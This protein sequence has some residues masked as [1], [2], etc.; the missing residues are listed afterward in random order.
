MT[1]SR[2]VLELAI[3][4]RLN[5][6]GRGNWLR[7]RLRAAVQGGRLRLCQPLPST[8][9]LARTLGLARGTVISAIEHLKAEGYLK[10]TPGSRI[11]VADTLPEAFLNPP[12]IP[13]RAYRSD[14]NTIALSKFATRLSPVNYYA[15]PRTVAFR[16]NFPAL[17]LFPID[18]WTKVTTRQWRRASTSMLAGGEPFGYLPLRISL[19]NYLRTARSVVCDPEQILITSGIQESLDL[20]TRILVNS[21]DR[22]L[23]EDPGFQVATAGFEAAGARVIPLSIDQE[24]AV[25]PAK[26]G[27]RAR[28][29]YVTPGH[30]FP[31]GATM[32]YERRV[33]I[34][35]YARKEETCIFE[36]DYDSEFRF[37][38]GPLPALQSL[39]S[40]AHVVFAGSFN[41]TLFPSLRI[42]YM[43]VPH[44]LIGAFRMSKSIRSRHHPWV[45][46]AVLHEF[47][48]EGHY[49]R[50][51]RKMRKV[52]SERLEILTEEVRKHLEGAIELSPVEAG[53]Q[54]VGWLQTAQDAE[55]IAA[56]ALEKSVDII[57]LSRYC[58]R[59]QVAPGFQ[60]GFAGVDGRSIARGVQILARIIS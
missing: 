1:R 43:V 8:R 19:C 58:R 15:K 39:D 44:C 10:S 31:T 7:D 12:P 32:S 23:M 20:S 59:K 38:G 60:I 45:D 6:Q 9:E 47:I 21:G 35:R 3:P 17:D 18:L 28:I 25:P 4:P 46:Q 40:K 57:P 36:D 5:E 24:G 50:H 54:T 30:Q 55:E 41:K 51:L 49:L 22:V 48:D 53:L 52:Y 37:A 42:G 34:L 29:M 26:R 56:V 13:S 33:Q 16:V 27:L 2:T 11:F 14:S